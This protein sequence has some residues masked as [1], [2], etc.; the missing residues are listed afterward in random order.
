MKIF[1]ITKKGTLGGCIDEFRRPSAFKGC[2]KD[3][4]RY[5]LQ[6][7]TRE[8]GYELH[9][10]ATVTEQGHSD[11]FDPSAFFGEPAIAFCM[12]PRKMGNTEDWWWVV[13]VNDEGLQRGLNEGWITQEAL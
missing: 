6:G 5:R 3:G 13:L 8:R 12:G 4:V 11:D 9:L 1:P 2:V 10:G 7:L